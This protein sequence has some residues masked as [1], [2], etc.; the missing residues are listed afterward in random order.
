MLKRWVDC[1]AHAMETFR[2]YIAG[3]Y[4]DPLSDRWMDSVDPFLNQPWCRIPRSDAADADVAVAAA[5]AAFEDPAWRGLSATARGKLL[6]R[7]G[8]LVAVNAEA[9]AQI[10]VR[11]NGKL[12]NEMLAQLRYI[13]E[14]YHYYGGLAD[15]VEGA[16]IPIDK[17]DCLTYTQYE[18]LGVVA[19]I[20]P[21]NSPLFLLAWKLAPG[22]AAGNT[23]VVKPSEHASA[24]TLAFARLA[25]EAGFP[26]GVINVV[27]GHGTEVGARLVEH[28]DVAK[29]AFTGADATGRRINET[30]ARSFKHVTMELGGKSPNIVFADADLDLAAAGVM[31]GIFAAAGQTCIAG[32]RLLVERSVHDALLDRVLALAK[33][34]KLGNPADPATQIGP[35]ANL[36]QFNKVL[37]CIAMAQ[38]EGAV[39]A[40]GGTRAGRSGCTQGLFI[41]PTVFSGVHNDMRIAREEVFGPVLV[42]IPFDGEDEAVRI[43]NDTL[44]GLAAG[45]WTRDMGRAMRT[46]NRVR[47]GTVW[48]NTYRALSYMAP[49]GGVK[50]SGLGRE[51]GAE[52]IKEY[53][54]MKTVWLSTAAGGPANAF[55]MR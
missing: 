16:V 54:Q 10:E 30:A 22:L 52:M 26:P 44:Y 9:L 43:A 25:H 24:S 11:D 47:A 46:V 32:S 15:K 38:S 12:I 37:D 35:M 6:H 18:P 28:P 48:V 49:F 40:L 29:I 42:A 53:L 14:W 34:A 19:A 39:L 45:V 31:S 23:F 5:K 27:A 3:R 17:A 4:V 2:N 33:K 50:Q 8:E 1:A 55:V 7:L 41:E 20:T 51:S 36:P 13:P 21:W